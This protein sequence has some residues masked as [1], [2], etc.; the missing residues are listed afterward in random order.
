[1]G[2]LAGEEE[3]ASG[4]FPDVRDDNVGGRPSEKLQ[5]LDVHRGDDRTPT[6]VRHRDN[7]GVNGALGSL[8]DA[9]KQLPGPDANACVDGI[10]LDSLTSQP[11]K[12]PSILTSA[13]HDF[14][15]DRGHGPDGELPA[16]HLRHESTHAIST[17]DRPMCNS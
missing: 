9:S 16:P 2:K 3:Q 17:S 5:I 7:K 1:V 4:P 11:C 12:D 10:D 8:A 15:Q 14:G 6:E 13:S